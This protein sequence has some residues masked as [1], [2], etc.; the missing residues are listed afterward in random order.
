VLG[1]AWLLSSA[2]SVE[3]WRRL[4]RWLDP[5]FTALAD[6]ASW[7][8]VKLLELLGPVLE[9]LVGVLQRWLGSAMDLQPSESPIDE[10]L[11]QLREGAPEY[12]GPPAWLTLITRYLCPGLGVV[13]ALLAIVMWLERRRRWQRNPVADESGLA[14]GQGTMLSQAGG[15][16]QQAWERLRGLAA[17][18]GQFGIGRRLYA[19][20]SVR[21]IYA[22]V[23][24]LAERR[25]FPRSPAQTPNEFL[26]ELQ[27]AF[28]A[29]D[30]DLSNITEAYVRVHYGEAPSSLQELEAL[31][32]CWRRVLAAPVHQGSA[33]EQNGL[34]HEEGNAL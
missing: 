29:C 21:H 31:R 9:W 33:S 5:V 14:S 6:A 11:T 34:A 3:G 30:S 26:P 23:V 28:P 22:N 19:A 10:F 25:G 27:R 18:V 2:Y 15:L 16:L 4:F 20:V 7:L 24:R 32:S 17:Q 12:A 8:V 13:L 1:V